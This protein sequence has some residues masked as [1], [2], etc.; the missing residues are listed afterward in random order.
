MFFEYLDLT[1]YGFREQD[2]FTCIEPT[3]FC[4]FGAEV[5]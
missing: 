3:V 1:F 5:A 4:I 2:V